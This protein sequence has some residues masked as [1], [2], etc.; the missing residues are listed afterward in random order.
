MEK[1]DGKKVERK[2][3]RKKENEKEQN[4]KQSRQRAQNHTL[5]STRNVG[6]SN[7]FVNRLPVNY[8]R[9]LQ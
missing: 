7:G 9:R 8:G 4:R 1:K 6:S 5:V 3:E 2:K